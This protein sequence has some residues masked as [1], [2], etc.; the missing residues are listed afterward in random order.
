MA[1]AVTTERWRK[2]QGAELCFWKEME[3]YELIKACAEKAEFWSRFDAAEIA[4]LLAARDVLEIGCGPLGLS[5]VS[6][7]DAEPPRKLVKTDPLT[8]LPVRDT[9]PALARSA[10]RFIDWVEEMAES[11]DYLQIAG[12][13]LAFDSAFDT[14]IAYNVLDHVRS[15]LLILENARRALRPGGRLILGVDCLSWLGRLRFEWITRR[16]ARGTILVDAHPHTFLPRDVIGM[17]EAA[18]L[19]LTAMRGVPRWVGRFAGR[20]FRPAFV[21]TK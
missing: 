12:E 18:G 4:D 16:L 8:R 1:A 14:V 17:I 20:H 21:A 3:L 9:R 5:V 13:D 15:P 11:G 7:S 6:F 2:A 19:K 10:T